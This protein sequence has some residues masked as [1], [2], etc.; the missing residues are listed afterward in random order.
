MSAEEDTSKL[1]LTGIPLEA[2]LSQC[3]DALKP[4]GKVVHFTFYPKEGPHSDRAFVDFADAASGA[5]CLE[6]SRQSKALVSDKLFTGSSIV[7]CGTPIVA[8]IRKDRDELLQRRNL[9]DKRN[10]HL[11]YEG[12]IVPGDPA[13][14]G[15]SDAEMAKRKKLFDKKLEKMADTNNKVSRTRLAVFNIPHGTTT[16]QIR[17][18]FAVAPK[19]YART[20]KKEDLAKTILKSSVRISEVRK[21]EGQDDVAFVEFTQH[22]H[23][24]GALRMVNNN[25]K[26][27]DGQRLIVEFAIE[28]SNATRKRRKKEEERKKM[29]AKRFAD[30]EPSLRDDDDENGSDEDEDE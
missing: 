14:E 20:H 5:A 18:I 27:F 22:E 19:Q 21:P 28:N 30:K 26:Y 2:T 25:P 4:F 9:A 12:R 15:V 24:L 29:R 10:Q 3:L 8:M 17:K 16:A 13:A 6:R 7:V 23:A 11:M 1:F